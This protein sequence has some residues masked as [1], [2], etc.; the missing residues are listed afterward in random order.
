MWVK[1]TLLHFIVDSGSQKNLI[2][3]KVVKQLGLSTTPHPQPYNI[4]WLRQ[5]RDLRVSQQCR[6]SYGIQPFKDEV[7]CDVAPLDVCDVLL[8]QPYMWRRHAVYESRPHSVIVTLGGHLY[9]IP[10]V[11]PTIV[12]PKKCRKVVSHTAKFSFFTI[13]SKGEQ[14]DTATTTASPPAPSIQQKQVDKVAA[15]RKDSFY[16]PSSHVARL[17]EPPQLQQVHDRLP[18]TK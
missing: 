13:C 17:V 9:R 3:T 5:G 4:G 14:K 8:G 16:I 2:S 6:L 10:E 11:V 15:K 18:Q 1:G 12:P 7:L